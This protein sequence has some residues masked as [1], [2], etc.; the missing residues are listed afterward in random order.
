MAAS[1]PRVNDGRVR[2]PGDGDRRRGY[3]G[4]PGPASL[5]PPAGV[6]S[7]AG[8]I[9]RWWPLLLIV[10]IAVVVV[11][12][13]LH[14]RAPLATPTP[15]PPPTASARSVV[16]RTAPTAPTSRPSMPPLLTD[17]APVTPRTTD[18]GRPV[19]NIS[20]GWELFGRGPDS[21][22]RIELAK[23]RITRTAVPG[24]GSSGPVSFWSGRTGPSSGRWTSFQDL[25]STMGVMPPNSP[26]RW[27]TAD[28]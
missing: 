8:R 21:M 23:G 27:A 3:G 20:A 22:V 26:E 28:R 14:P 2:K 10:L 5:W 6:G 19:L 16:S 13:V 7:S 25:P 18:L 4:H 17:P 9:T 11:A 24:L 1:G 15:V 12:V